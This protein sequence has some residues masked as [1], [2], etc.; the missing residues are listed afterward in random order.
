MNK[1]FSIFIVSICFFVS[2]WSL[3]SQANQDYFKVHAGALPVKIFVGNAG[4]AGSLLGVDGQ[5]GIIYAQMEGAGKMQLEL[6]GLKKQNI[7]GFSFVWPQDAMKT[8]QMYSR[9]VQQRTSS[10]S[11]S[12]NV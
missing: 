6:R 9:T 3:L 5:K 4:K 10:C 7:R 12:Y 1:Y 11:S 8:L 2:P